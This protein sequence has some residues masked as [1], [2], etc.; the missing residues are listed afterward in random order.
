VPKTPGLGFV[1]TIIGGAPGGAF[2]VLTSTNVNASLADWT[3]ALTNQFDQF[4]VFTITGQHDVAELQ[5]YF[6][7]RTP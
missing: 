3:T 4:G 2:T 6:R 5:R 7:V 1:P